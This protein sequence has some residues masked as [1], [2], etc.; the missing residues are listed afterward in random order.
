MSNDYDYDP[1]EHGPSLEVILEGARRAARKVDDLELDEQ[2]ATAAARRD[3]HAA[4]GSH[5]VAEHWQQALLAFHEVRRERQQTRRQ[6]EDI[7]TPVTV[8]LL[9]AEELAEDDWTDTPPEP[10]C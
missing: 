1:E 4:H 8:C 5:A 10:P 9:T 3:V 6:F 7:T 2:I